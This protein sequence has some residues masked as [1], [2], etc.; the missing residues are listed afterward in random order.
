[1]RKNNKLMNYNSKAV[2]NGGK[3]LDKKLL[4]LLI[5]LLLCVSGCSKTTDEG[6]SEPSLSA[7][8][9]TEQSD[10]ELNEMFPVKEKGK[11]PPTSFDLIQEALDTQK[12]SKQDAMI[13]RLIA[14]FSPE[15]LPKTYQSTETASRSSLQ[16][17][18]KWL[19]KNYDSLDEDTQKALK[20]YYVLPDDPGYYLNIKKPAEKLKDKLSYFINNVS[21]VST[22]VA[23]T[24]VWNK[25]EASAGTAKADI[26]Y[27]SADLQQAKYIKA[28]FEKSTPKFE[29]LL[30][31]KVPK[32]VFY[33][34]P[35]VDWGIQVSRVING[36][37]CSY[38]RIKKGLNKKRTLST[39]AHEAFHSHQDWMNLD[40]SGERKWLMEATATWAE[41]YAYGSKNV[42]HRWLK[43]FFI[44]LGKD[45]VYFGNCREYTTYVWPLFLT[46]YYK[47]PSLIRIILNK[48]RKTDPRVA[49]TTGFIKKSFDTLFSEYALWNLNKFTAKYYKDTKPII[50]T[51]FR[52]TNYQF[53]R[54]KGKKQEESF[55]IETEPLSAQYL[56]FI[57][58]GCKKIT[59]DMKEIAKKNIKR[60]ALIKI[61]GKWQK[62]P[63]D[64]SYIK[65]KKF[66]SD[67]KGEKIEGL[68]LIISNADL[69]KGYYD[70]LTVKVYEDCE[71]AWHG[72]TTITWD[73]EQTENV[74]TVGGVK[75]TVKKV[76]KGKYVLRDELAMHEPEDDYTDYSASIQSTSI[77]YYSF[78]EITKTLPGN[79]GIIKDV[80]G[81]T[82]SGTL[83]LD[84]TEDEYPPNR[85]YYDMEFPDK[86]I[87][88][89]FDMN[90]DY[91]WI[92]KREVSSKRFNQGCSRLLT[93]K[94]DYTSTTERYDNGVTFYPVKNI[95]VKL[96]HENSFSG[97]HTYINHAKGM[98]YE[99]KVE[100]EYEYE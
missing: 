6:E 1:M 2:V 68:I 51:A 55:S 70:Y 95:K 41:N 26:F 76:K 88:L 45:M 79:C 28:S 91:K 10:P 74:V 18:V 90:V 77:D 36:V 58:E 34:V 39:T 65:K 19:E 99:V 86:G 12:I 16:E 49:A 20:P 21:F 50:D 27:K 4:I 11:L 30:K 22:A 5:V 59:I 56:G 93:P 32:T 63:Q 13:L 94:K 89:D 67:R 37:N 53:K 81:R 54:F 52:S 80:F 46:Q 71:P 66:C 57:F 100:Y 62:R 92:K 33:I 60:R 3:Q 73:A 15:G 7:K 9:D 98:S 61:G 29:S 8:P 47:N 43:D 25:I 24:P 96:P 84:F 40:Y 75:G 78:Y 14:G 42:E 69:K 23:S 38:I 44:N 35:I 48:S 87:T 17:A 64:W 83:E 85:L 31:V 72:T 97:T 82:K